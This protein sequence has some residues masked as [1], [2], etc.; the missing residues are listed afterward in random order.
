[1]DVHLDGKRA[2][3]LASSKGIGRASAMELA[4]EG[5]SVAISSRS[6]PNLEAAKELIVDETGVPPERISTFT[7]DLSDA[8]S[9]ADRVTAAIERLGGL[10]VLV[11]NSGGPDKIGF[12]DAT[13]EQFDETYEL[14]VKSVVAAIDAALPALKDGGGA[15]TN[16]IAASVQQPEANHVLANTVRP[17]IY[18]LAKS[19]SHEYADDGIRVNNVCPKKVGPVTPQERDRTTHIGRYADEHDLSYE[20]ARE[21][22]I[23]QIIPRGT[24]GELEEFG[25]AVA[26]VSSGAATHVTGHSLNVDGGW[27]RSTF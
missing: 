6:E 9:V 2:I 12:E 13:L 16:I 1:M 4:R 8:A 5:A 24:Y 15:I 10:D 11:T 27:V 25:K 18:G 21:E 3:V 7:C 22:Y 17:S 20:E 23:A 19:L 26:Y 14:I